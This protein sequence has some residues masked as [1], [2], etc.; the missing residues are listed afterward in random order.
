MIF[1]FKDKSFDDVLE[2]L[3]T[4]YPPNK[5]ITAM[6]VEKILDLADE[7]QIVE[8]NKRCRQFLMTQRGKF[9]Y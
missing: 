8:L 2:L 5:P 4:I 7:Y 6:N 9:T 3:Q 1:V